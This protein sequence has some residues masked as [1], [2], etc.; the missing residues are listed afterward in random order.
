MQKNT[1]ESNGLPKATQE[2]KNTLGFLL[3]GQPWT[4]KGIRGT[5][6]LSIDFDPNFNNGIFN[7]VAYDF[8]KPNSKQFKIGIGDSLNFIDAPEVIEFKR[9][10]ISGIAVTNFECGYKIPPLL[11]SYLLI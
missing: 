1:I 4:P 5:G 2:G 3:N 11:I 7:I 6:N 9:K 10:G 8:S